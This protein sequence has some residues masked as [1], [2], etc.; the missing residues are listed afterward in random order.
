M[1]HSAPSLLGAW[2]PTCDDDEALILRELLGTSVWPCTNM[3]DLFLDPSGW[4]SSMAEPGAWPTP[5]WD[6]YSQAE[7]LQGE[8]LPADLCMA[9]WLA[10]VPPALDMRATEPDPAPSTSEWPLSSLLCLDYQPPL[11]STPVPPVPATDWVALLSAYAAHAE[12]P[13]ADEGSAARPLAWAPCA[14][15][16]DLDWLGPWTAEGGAT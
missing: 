5:G 2:F 10:S 11:E 3:P 9:S 1:N 14:D 15:W 13:A 4:A 8:P 12:A 7:Y 16:L 6:A